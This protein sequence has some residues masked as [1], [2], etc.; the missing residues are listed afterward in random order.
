MKR[1]RFTVDNPLFDVH[2]Q[3]KGESGNYTKH[4]LISV[5]KGLLYLRDLPIWQVTDNGFVMTLLILGG[6]ISTIGVAW[7]GVEPRV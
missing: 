7:C 2:E 5:T 1:C 3:A 4:A 6:C